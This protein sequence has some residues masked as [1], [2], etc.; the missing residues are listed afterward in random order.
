MIENVQSQLR[1]HLDAGEVLLWTGIPRQGITL[2]SADVLLIPFSLMW[3]GFAVF[4]ETMVIINKT[5]LFFKLWGIPF[6]LVG[7]YLIFGRFLLD[8]KRREKT[9]YGLTETR[10]I[11]KSGVFKQTIY[12][13]NI[14]TLTNITLHEKAD[15]SGTIILGHESGFGLFRG[16][17][18]LTG[19]TMTPAIE[20][21][22][23]ASRVYRQLTELQA[24]SGR[25]RK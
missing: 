24:K 1:P 25:Y 13:L 5:P 11:I 14:N 16:T 3:G 21:I 4:W 20:M 22:D 17:G 8:A 6:V 7:F 9:F 2:K 15:K 18:W 23:N 19:K 10:V 12:S